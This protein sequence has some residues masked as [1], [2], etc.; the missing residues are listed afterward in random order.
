MGLLFR[1]I[2]MLVVPV[3][4]SLLCMNESYFCRQELLTPGWVSVPAFYILSAGELLLSLSL[5]FENEL[6]V[7][8]PSFIY[9]RKI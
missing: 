4:A 5:N 2:K 8:L 7:I 9:F 3:R 6:L 1:S